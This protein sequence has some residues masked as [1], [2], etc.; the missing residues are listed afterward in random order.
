MAFTV[1]DRSASV[2]I[3]VE[4]VSLGHDRIE[5]ELQ[6]LAMGGQIPS[7]ELSSPLSV[8]ADRVAAGGQSAEA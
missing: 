5:A 2:P 3:E 6:A 7:G 8:F 4:I 1:S